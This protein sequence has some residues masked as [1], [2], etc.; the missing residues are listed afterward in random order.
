LQ[1]E[2]DR[3]YFIPCSGPPDMALTGMCERYGDDDN[4]SKRPR[5]DLWLSMM[6]RPGN[7][8]AVHFRFVADIV[9]RL[10]QC[11]LGEDE[12]NLAHLLSHDCDQFEEYGE[13][14]DMF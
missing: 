3:G 1:S 11:A 6:V 14:C 10:L 13:T 4:E 5:A 7:V 2:I 12:A 8:F 9:F